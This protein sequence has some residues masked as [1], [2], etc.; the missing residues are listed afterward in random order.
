MD[1]WRETVLKYQN[2][3]KFI[4]MLIGNKVDL[5]NFKEVAWDKGKY[6]AT[7]KRIHL[8]Y[9]TSA[10]LNIRIEEAMQK[11][12]FTIISNFD[13]SVHRPLKLVRK[14]GTHRGCC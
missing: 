9:E 8:F 14:E 4:E 12:G 6:W 11:L 10:L 7:S 2:S 13:D 1:N 3:Q 5:N